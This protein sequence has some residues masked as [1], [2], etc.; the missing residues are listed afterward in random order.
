M[1]RLPVL[2]RTYDFVKWLVPAVTQ[3]PRQQRYLLGERLELAALDLLDLLV[4]A[5]LVPETRLMTL[6][7]AAV[8]VDR[9]LYLLRLS[10][11]L[12]LLSGPRYANACRVLDEVGRQVS[13]WMR[14]S[15]RREPMRSPE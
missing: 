8:R 2:E 9:L 14:A 13:G 3:F 5:R 11:D 6:R 10:H 12:E 7:K 15:S 4:E 1:N